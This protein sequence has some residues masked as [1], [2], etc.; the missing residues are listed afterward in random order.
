M[1]YARL[2]KE[3]VLLTGWTLAEN[4]M[5]A[6]LPQAIGASATF[7]LFISFS[8]FNSIN[9]VCQKELEGDTERVGSKEI[10]MFFFKGVCSKKRANGPVFKMGLECKEKKWKDSREQILTRCKTFTVRVSQQACAH[11]LTM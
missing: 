9:E 2:R 6:A 1:I 5:A 3:K 8:S 11:A 10:K 4:K 7:Y